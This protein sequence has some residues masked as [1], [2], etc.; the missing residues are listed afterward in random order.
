[1]DDFL[2]NLRSGKLKQPDRPNRQYGDQ[3]YKGGARRNMNVMDRRKR[4]SDARESSERLNVIKELLENLVKSQ[5]KLVEAYEARI[6]VEERKAL[7]MEVLAENIYRMFNPKTAD[8]D[9]LS[10]NVATPNVSITE[11]VGFP[12][13]SASD[14]SFENVQSLETDPVS[15]EAEAVETG[16]D[17][18]L[19]SFLKTKELD[20]SARDTKKL[21][22]NDRQIIVA[23]IK[24]MRDNGE[25]WEQ[26]ARQIADM[27]FP[28]L[29]GKGSWRGIMAKNLFEKSLA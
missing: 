19:N 3:Q 5:K 18:A 17:S 15:A 21:N 10:N 29:S 1:M 23:Q 7:A 26:I 22:E 11:P 2:H 13:A 20:D 9:R 24:Q 16:S 28:T 25:N 4:E 6:A 8:T 12:A 14:K 27:G